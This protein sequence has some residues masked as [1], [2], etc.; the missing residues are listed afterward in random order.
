MIGLW[1]D[2]FGLDLSYYFSFPQSI[3]LFTLQVPQC[4]GILGVQRSCWIRC[5]T[6]LFIHADDDER[7]HASW[8]RIY[9]ECRSPPRHHL[10]TNVICS[11]K[12]T[13][14]FRFDWPIFSIRFNYWTECDPGD[15]RQEWEQLE[16][17]PG[18]VCYRR[19]WVSRR[20]LWRKRAERAVCSSEMGRGE[21]RHGFQH[22]V[23]G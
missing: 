12:Q 22:G 17:L 16:G 11:Q 14:V 7:A 6:K 3:D 10:V 13:T 20:R 8:V 1:T 5:R 15:H 9:G 2:K 19:S 21:A 18:T 23:F 4:L